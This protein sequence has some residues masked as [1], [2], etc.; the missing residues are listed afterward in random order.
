MA[1]WN[2][3]CGEK[4]EGKEREKPRPNDGGSQMLRK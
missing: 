4:K 1:A 3:R 2:F